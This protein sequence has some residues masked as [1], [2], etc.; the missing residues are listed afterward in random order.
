[1]RRR[2]CRS[3]RSCRS[4]RR[5]GRGRRRRRGTT[6]PCGYVVH[7]QAWGQRRCIARERREHIQILLDAAECRRQPVVAG[8]SVDHRQRIGA[9]GQEHLEL[10][11]CGT[12]RAVEVVGLPP[13]DELPVGRSSQRLRKDTAAWAGTHTFIGNQILIVREQGIQKRTMGCW[14]RIHWHALI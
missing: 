10:G 2:C 7:T 6:T 5:R 9:F 13:D 3:W 4:V 8:H 1:M 11:L 14:I 12:R